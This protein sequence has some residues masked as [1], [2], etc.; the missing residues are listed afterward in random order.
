MLG[1]ELFIY[2]MNKIFNLLSTGVSTQTEN[3][4]LYDSTEKVAG[5]TYY[6]FTKKDGTWEIKKVDESTTL[7]ITYA[8]Y[9]NNTNYDN[10]RDAFDNYET[11][12]YSD[13]DLME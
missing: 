12:T 11:L 2:W 7:N 1:S 10:I 9:T 13:Y 6:G 4:A 5:V 3:F 8:R